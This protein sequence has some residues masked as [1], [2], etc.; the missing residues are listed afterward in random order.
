MPHIHRALIS[1]SDKRGLA[2]FAKALRAMNVEIISTGGTYTTLHEAGIDVRPVSDITQF[3]EILGGRVK[4]L[5]PKIHGALLA[6]ADNDEHVRQLAELDIEPI[7]LVAVNLYPFDATIAKASV[8][9][10]DAIEHIDIGGPTMVRAAA[11]NFKYKAVVVNPD[12]YDAII[13]EMRSHHCEISAATCFALAKEAF[14]HI[15]AYDSAISSYLDSV[16]PTQQVFPDTFHIA[17]KKDLDLRYGE[18]PHQRG[19]LYGAFTEMFEKLHGKELSYNNIVDIAAAAELVAEFDEPTV[20]IIKHTNPCGVG[21]APNLAEAY[22]KAFATDTKSAF[23]GIVAMNRP[24]DMVASEVMNE[25]FTEVIVA[26]SFDEGALEFLKRKKDRRLIRNNGD[27]R[28]LNSLDIKSIPGGLLVQQSDR[29]RLAPEKL[30]V[31]TQ[32]KPKNEELLSMAFAWRVAKH[33]KSNAIVYA[34]A[35]RT[36]GVGAGQ[37][38]RVDSARVATWKAAEMGLSV[39]G[40]AVGSDAFFPFADGLIEAVHAGSTCVIQPGGS[41]RDEEVIAAADQHDIAMV[42]TGVRHFRH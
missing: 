10:D 13:A 39:R 25:I 28:N 23:G 26:P 2:E 30:K 33:V 27:L 9:L 16:Q 34:L 17:L 15:T 36:I 18:N 24:L 4:T 8:T 40:S 22:A 3:P 14:R 5:H 42:F 19:M 20:A 32:R 41:L 37:M 1:V 7:D 11:K 35:D 12:R 21:S 31:V 6:V 29:E 38:S